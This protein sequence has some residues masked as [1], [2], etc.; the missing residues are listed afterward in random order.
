MKEHRWENNR[1]EE[2]IKIQMKKEEKEQ[3]KNGI[4]G[5]GRKQVRI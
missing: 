2:T 4:T 5:E 1:N 3:E